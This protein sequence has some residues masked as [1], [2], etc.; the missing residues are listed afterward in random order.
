MDVLEDQVDKVQCAAG[1]RCHQGHPEWKDQGHLGRDFGSNE[2]KSPWH[3]RIEVV[4]GQHCLP[5]AGIDRVKGSP[6][7]HA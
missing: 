5:P 4:G 7:S 1:S 3:R 6:V 2:T